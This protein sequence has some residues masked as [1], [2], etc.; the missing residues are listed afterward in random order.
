MQRTASREDKKLGHMVVVPLEGP[1]D[2]HSQHGT[3]AVAENDERDPR[4]Q[5]AH[6]LDSLRV[7]HTHVSCA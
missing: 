3:E 1:G 6:R 2:A 7:T 4:L 5:V